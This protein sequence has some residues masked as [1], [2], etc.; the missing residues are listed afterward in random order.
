MQ[1]AKL[2]IGKKYIYKH[3]V[4]MGDISVQAERYMKCFE[5]EDEGA[6]FER[7]FE[8]LIFLTEEE[9]KNLRPA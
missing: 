5:I 3:T 8:P 2:Q 6:Y 4:V 1:K 9:I 7:D